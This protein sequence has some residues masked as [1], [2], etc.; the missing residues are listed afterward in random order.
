MVDFA[1]HSNRLSRTFEEEKSPI[2][3]EN[4]RNPVSNLD[5]RHLSIISRINGEDLDD[6]EVRE[7][8][9]LT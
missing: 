4:A 8:K 2:F 9:S 1:K 3:L 7:F 5:S 6:L